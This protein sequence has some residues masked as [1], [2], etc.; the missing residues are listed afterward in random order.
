[1]VTRLSVLTFK[2]DSGGAVRLSSCGSSSSSVGRLDSVARGE[3]ARARASWQ[4]P[5]QQD[6]DGGVRT[7]RR[8]HARRQTHKDTRNT[9]AHS[10]QTATHKHLLYTN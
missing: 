6:A 10:T 5:A 7:R 2:A 3:V 9:S 1:M 4:W 8:A